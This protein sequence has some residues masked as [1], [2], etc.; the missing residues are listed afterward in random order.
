MFLFSS[1]YVSS[2]VNA[3][4]LSKCIFQSNLLLP[5]L[6]YP[7]PSKSIACFPRKNISF[8]V[9]VYPK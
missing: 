2:P 9:K 6:M 8:L 7:L 4:L 3:S 1:K 5:Q